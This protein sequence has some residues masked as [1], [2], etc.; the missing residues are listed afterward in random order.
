[1]GPDGSGSPRESS[2]FNESEAKVGGKSFANPRGLYNPAKFMQMPELE[3]R[4]W[5][6]MTSLDND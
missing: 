2:L 6:T 4:R 5:T 3:H 1:V